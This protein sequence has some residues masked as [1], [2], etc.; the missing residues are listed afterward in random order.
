MTVIWKMNDQATL[1]PSHEEGLCLL[2][3]FDGPILVDSEEE[4]DNQTIIDRDMNW[5][6]FY[7]RT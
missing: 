6:D 1:H 5:K 4:N 2:A 7:P 3:E